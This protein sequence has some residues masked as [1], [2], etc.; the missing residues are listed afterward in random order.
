MHV[1]STEMAQFKGVWGQIY[2]HQVQIKTSNYEAESLVEWR[3]IVNGVMTTVS[4]ETTELHP[5]GPRNNGKQSGTGLYPDYVPDPETRLV[6][7]FPNPPSQGIPWSPVIARLGFYDYGN[8]PGFESEL[9][10]LDGGE[11]DMFYPAWCRSFQQDT[12]WRKA[13]DNRYNISWYKS[14]FADDTS[15]VPPAIEASPIPQGS[16]VEHP[17]VGK[18]YQFLCD[19]TLVGN[20]SFNTLID[21]SLKDAK[22]ATHDTTLYYPISL[23]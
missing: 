12:L 6:L 13:A 4:S 21:A 8:D 9:N 5:F 19:T 20:R 17:Q 15:Y 2:V 16:Y 14:L 10:K 22:L 23:I 18:V 1:S 7:V 11:K 3:L